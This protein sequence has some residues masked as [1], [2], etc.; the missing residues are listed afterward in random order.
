[1]V[2]VTGTGAHAR[3][4][5]RTARC[6]FSCSRVAITTPVALCQYARNVPPWTRAIVPHREPRV[7]SPLARDGR[8]ASRAGSHASRSPGGGGVCLRRIPKVLS[9]YT[10]SHSERSLRV[11]DP[12]DTPGYS[13][14]RLPW[15][16]AGRCRGRAKCERYRDVQY[17][18][19]SR[20]MRRSPHNSRA[21]ACSRVS[22]R[23]MG[24]RHRTRR[25]VAH[26]GRVG[27]R[28][29]G[30]VWLDQ[31]GVDVVLVVSAHVLFQ[32]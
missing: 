20:G 30:W 10:I 6:P 28:L 25:G 12:P 31:R 26:V 14:L 17:P 15:S 13:G 27:S 23:P 19:V 16:T 22:L 11:A 21:A 29:R 1:V 4:A 9:G 32:Q 7:N 8:P 24:S 3:G 5:G 2:G 18:R